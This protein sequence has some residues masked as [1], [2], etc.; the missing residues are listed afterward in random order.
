M[1]LLS[2]SL[3]RLLAALATSSVKSLY[4]KTTGIKA[5]NNAYSRAASDVR[6]RA[7]EQVETAGMPTQTVPVVPT[8]GPIPEVGSSRWQLH[9]TDHLAQAAATA[10]RKRAVNGSHRS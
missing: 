1:H 5:R 10:A 9:Y 6:R 2:P 4:P 8:G 3:R 7:L